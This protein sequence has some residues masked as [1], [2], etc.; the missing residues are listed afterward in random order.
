[1]CNGSTGCTGTVSSAN[2]LVGSTSNDQIGSAGVLALSN[3]NFVVRSTLWD[4]TAPP[5]V[6]AG[7]ITWCSG[8]TG[9]TGVVSSA[10]SLI[11]TTANDNIGDINVTALAN[12]NYVVSSS[13]WDN[14]GASNAGAVTF[15]SGTTGC[16]G[17]VSAANSLVG[18]TMNDNVG[19]PGVAGNGV[20]GLINGNYVVVSPNWNNGAVADAGA[21]TFCN[22]TTGCAGTIDSSNSLVGGTA[23]NLI[24]NN[25]VTALT[26]SNGN[27][28]VI[29]QTWDDGATSNVGAVTLCNGATGCTGLVSS[30]NSLIGST[31]GDNIGN[32]GVTALN[33]GNYVVRSRSW[34][35]AA[36]STGAVTWC[37]GTVGCTGAVTT[38]NS[39]VGSSLNDQIGNSGVTALS[40]GNYIV[41]SADWNIGA[42]NVGAVTWC[43][44]ASGCTGPITAANSLVGSTGGDNV[45]S[46]GVTA[47]G[48][49]NYLVRSSSW[50][51][52]A[53]GSAGAITFCDGATGCTGA[54]TP[55]NSLVGSTGG[56][57]VGSTGLIALSNNNYVVLS[58]NWDGG[59]SNSGAISYGAGYAATSVGPIGASNSI[60]GTAASGGINLIFGFSTALQQLVVGRRSDNVVSIF[61]P[62]HT[63]IADGDWGDP[64]TWDY[65]LPAQEQDVVIPNGRDVTLNVNAAVKGLTVESGGT[66]T[67]SDGKLTIANSVSVACTGAIA[68]GSAM[69]YIIGNVEKDYC[70]TGAFNYPTGTPNGY[71]PVT[72]DIITLTTNPSSLAVKAVEGPHPNS[73]APASALGR[74]WALAETGDLTA[75]LT[76]NY[77]QA[78]VPAVAESS[79]ELKRYTGSGTIFDT[80][81]ATLDTGTNAATTTNGITDFSDWTMLGPVT[82]GYLL[83]PSGTYLPSRGGASSFNLS[84]LASCAW[85]ATSNAP[86]I[87][88]TS[89]GTGSGSDIISFE[90]REN[91]TASARQ[92]QI[93]IG[94]EIFSVVQESV[95]A[96]CSYT[97]S[98]QFATF[99]VGGGSGTV[100]VTT[101]A[102]CGWQA[103]SNQSWIVI[104]PPSVGVGGATVNYS[105]LANASGTSRTGVITI[106][107]R[108]IPIKQKGS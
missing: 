34:S 67:L 77:L 45:G 100:S 101:G 69:S 107:G 59:A 51:N 20:T 94:G 25:G 16:T 78:D 52:G 71:S 28:V 53:I 31:A 87:V 82:C 58:P 1:L 32:S 73:P 2:S 55:S 76:F 86:W 43:N 68:G 103:T 29:S 4:N 106:G 65:G 47:L 98:P 54:I 80:I 14:V 18:S 66:L 42:D 3:G 56:D 96:S 10:N 27:Y 91:L 9:C 108:K 11:G 23:S 24:G 62:F 40:S 44:G 39:L 33:N 19:T 41:V 95:G 105:V 74:Y 72:A 63:A 49:G 46:G 75:T 35:G 12:G 83:S 89:S 99:A 6:N 61:R 48:N 37:D 92:G 15:C 57:S 97:V 84:T 26:L 30:A 85:E 88:I 81:P 22:G 70:A 93:T 8:A 38:S 5:A 50:D 64:A 13:V 102:E 104:T 79:L 7:A 60:R 21:A 17:A 90:T 36:L